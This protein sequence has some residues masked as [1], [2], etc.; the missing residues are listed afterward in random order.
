MIEDMKETDLMT[1]ITKIK[2]EA[3]IGREI[4]RLTKE[5][6]P[7]TPGDLQDSQTGLTKKADKITLDPV[8]QLETPE[9]TTITIGLLEIII[10]VEITEEQMI[11]ANPIDLKG[12]MT[13]HPRVMETEE[14]LTE[15]PD[16]LSITLQLERSL[17]EERAQDILQEMNSL[18]DLISEEVTEE[19]EVVM[20]I[21]VVTEEEVTEVIE[22]VSEEEE[23]SVEE[24]GEVEL[25]MTSLNITLLMKKRQGKQHFSH[26]KLWPC[27]M[28]ELQAM[29]TKAKATTLILVMIRILLD[30]VKAIRINHLLTINRLLSLLKVVL[31]V[32]LVT[33][34]FTRDP[35]NNELN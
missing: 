13:T 27:P 22:V 1:L 28:E 23:D 15:A 19:T 25:M 24:E 6:V 35:R 11:E 32:S 21:E 5:V 18:L 4:D 31:Q 29:M 16:H 17:K 14:I 33:R 30:M 2:V 7:Q 34:I 10:K 8:T 20:R 9:G 26:S 3:E 12:L